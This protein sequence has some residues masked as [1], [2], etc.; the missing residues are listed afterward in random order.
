V[1]EEPQHPLVEFRVE[2]RCRRIA[3]VERMRLE[4]VERRRPGQS[5]QVVESGQDVE[6]VRPD[7]RGMTGKH[8]AQHE[9]DDQ[10]RARLAERHEV[11]EAPRELL[12][13]AR[14]VEHGAERR[15]DRERAPRGERLDVARVEDVHTLEPG[16]KTGMA[17]CGRL[18]KLVLDVRHQDVV[19]TIERGRRQI[20]H[21]AADFQPP[22]ADRE[23]APVPG[24]RF[25]EVEGRGGEIRGDLVGGDAEVVVLDLPPALGVTHQT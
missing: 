11:A 24:D 22:R 19:A 5:R 20:T 12:P 17:G 10:E 3:M 4:N 23:L 21:S 16:T 14:V 13:I 25:P 18:E 8:L 9:V 15:H 2:R 1:E 7:R 6:E